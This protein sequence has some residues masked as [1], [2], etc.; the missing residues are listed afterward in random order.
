MGW[1]EMLMYY[2]FVEGYISNKDDEDTQLIP[3]LVG[4]TV[5]P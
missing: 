2:G 3:S 1:F 4:K 5:L